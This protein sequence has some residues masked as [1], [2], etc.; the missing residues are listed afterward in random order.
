MNSQVKNTNSKSLFSNNSNVNNEMNTDDVRVKMKDRKYFAE[1]DG[2]YLYMEPNNKVRKVF[3][4]KF[5]F[6]GES[7][8]YEKT[9][10][11]ENV[12]KV[13][14]ILKRNMHIIME[15]VPYNLEDLIIGKEKISFDNFDKNEIV[16]GLLLA[17]KQLH[18][19]NI[20]HNDYKAKNIQI[21]SDSKVKVIDFDLSDFGVKNIKKKTEE[22]NKLKYIILQILY[23]TKY[24]PETYKNRNKYLNQINDSKF[25]KVMQ[26]DRYNLNELHNF[27]SNIDFNKTESIFSDIK[28]AVNNKKEIYY[29]E[30]ENTKNT[31]KE[32][33]KKTK[34]EKTKNTKKEDTKKTKKEEN[35]DDEFPSDAFF[36]GTLTKKVKDV[37][38]LVKIMGK[39]IRKYKKYMKK[40]ENV[41]L[42]SDELK[43]TLDKWFQHDNE[44][45]NYFDYLVDENSE[46][47]ENSFENICDRIILASEDAKNTKKEK[48]S[49][50]SS[51]KSKLTKT[52]LDKFFSEFIY[53]NEH[54]CSSASH[55]S[56]YFIKK[57]ALIKIINKKYPEVRAELPDG[58][59]KLPKDKIC[60]ILFKLKKNLN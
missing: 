51:K 3:K 55:S 14:S 25:R 57:P 37:D 53:N 47:S 20:I 35:G 38:E 54:E 10:G 40:K 30:K 43:M 42:T 12:V 5:A 36:Y 21:T 27:T 18:G 56:K 49:N 13:Y 34:K 44:R 19:R 22:V 41:D 2:G 50:I 45:K 23:N 46:N 16:N 60:S 48:N 26:Y 52:I 7:N 4:S 11:L 33:M 32:N 31:K 15:F 8:V 24:Y 1:G 29:L 39:G 6:D 17:V 59:Q 9:G 28:Y 58:Y